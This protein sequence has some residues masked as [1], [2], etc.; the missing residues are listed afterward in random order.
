[1]ARHVGKRI[2]L[3]EDDAVARESMKLLLNIDRHSVTEAAD[4]KEAQALFAQKPFDLV[5]SD[6]F[7]PNMLGNELAANL[8]RRVPSQP[9][10]IV[11]GYFEKL[12]QTGVPPESL[13][14]KPFGV[15]QLR[16]AISKVLG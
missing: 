15:E 12:V 6:Y 16:E 13:L 14:A 8:W 4:G 7:M 2:L 11:S 3:V 9:I 5:I 10:L 1:M